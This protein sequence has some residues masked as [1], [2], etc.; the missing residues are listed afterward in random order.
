MM[1]WY[2]VLIETEDKL[3][4]AYSVENNDTCDGRLVFDKHTY[5]M[6]IVQECSNEGNHG[7]YGPIRGRLMNHRYQVGKKMFVAIG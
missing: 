2:I 5:E 3:V 1:A 7:M 4:V 6:N